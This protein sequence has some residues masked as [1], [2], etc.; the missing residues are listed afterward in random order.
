MFDSGE[1]S[2]TVRAVYWHYYLLLPR[3]LANLCGRPAQCSHRVRRPRRLGRHTVTVVN[4]LGSTA[5]VNVP[6]WAPSTCSMPVEKTRELKL[7]CEQVGDGV[8]VIDVVGELDMVTVPELRTYLAQKTARGPRHLVLDLAGVSFLA[9]YG[10]GLLLAS[11]Q[12]RHDIRGE[13]HLTGVTTNRAE[14]RVLDLTCT[15]PR[16]DIH[17]DRDELLRN[18]AGCPSPGRAE[19]QSASSTARHG[20]YMCPSAVARP[21][22]M[23]PSF[24][25]IDSRAATWKTPRRLRYRS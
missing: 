15:T 25:P 14:Q 21:S 8:I 10:L 23:R 9:S 20:Q 3:A 24:R 12:G 22:R 6:V 4:E 5:V 16:F 2:A 1:A 7:S 17:D 19:R 11:H 13:L 18:L